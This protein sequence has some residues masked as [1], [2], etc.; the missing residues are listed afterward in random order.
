[1]RLQV[2]WDTTYAYSQPVRVLHTELRVLPANRFG[3]KVTAARLAIE[4][5]AH[6]SIAVDAF[7]NQVNHFDHLGSVDRIHIAMEATVDTSGG[8][9]EAAELTPLDR[10]LGLASTTRCPFGTPIAT[11][12][13]A[14]P[15]A[16]AVQLAYDVLGTMASRFE[17]QVGHTDVTDT[18]LG[19]LERG[20]GVCQDFAHLMLAAMRMRRVPCRYVSGYL[21]TGQGAEATHAWVQAWHDGAWHGYD[22]ANN[23][24]QDERYVIIGVGRDYDDVAPIRGSYRGLAEEEWHAVV[25]VEAATNQ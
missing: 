18:A 23:C 12:L 25:S 17:F 1:M 6:M 16:P 13:D 10:H 22:P 3:Q 11:F 15:D 4:P 2:S 24:P 19:L 7:G 9:V 8:V 21:A 5:E 14:M 20:R